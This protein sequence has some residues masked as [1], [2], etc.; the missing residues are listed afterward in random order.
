MAFLMQKNMNNTLQI[1]N[2]NIV[3]LLVAAVAAIIIRVP[4][5]T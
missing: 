3:A 4:L 2:S 5:V 1:N